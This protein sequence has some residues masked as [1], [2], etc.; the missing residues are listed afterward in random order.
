VGETTLIA[1]GIG[2]NG[3]TATEQFSIEIS[4][5]NYRFF[6][7]S[8]GN[9]YEADA[10]VGPDGTWQQVVAVDDDVG[11]NMYI[12]IN[13]ELQDSKG[14]APGGLN[15]TT[16]PVS[17][18]SKRTG[19]D[20]NYNGGFTGTID[21]VAIYG[22]A[23]SA[24]QVQAHY[25]AAYGPSLPPTISKQP[26]SLTN[27]VTLPGIFSVGV[28]GTV[29][30]SYQWKKGGVPLTDD[31]I[32]INGA[33][34]A[35]L[36]VS[37]LV[38]G[39]SGNYSV[40]ITNVNGT[41]NSATVTLTVLAAPVTPPAIPGLV[42]HLPFDNNL[43]D[44]TG[45]GNNGTG[46]H[47]GA[48]APASFVGDGVLGAA[49]HYETDTNSVSTNYVSLGVRPD[50]Q[51]GPGV[52]FSVAYWIRLPLGYNKGDLPFLCNVPNSTFSSGGFTFAP[53]YGDHGTASTGTANG[54][55]GMSVYD[56]AGSG[57]G[58][59]GDIHTIDNSQWHHL[60]HVIDRDPTTA[61]TV[62]YLD[63]K[64]ARGN[65][66]NGTTAGAAGDLT[67]TNATI[68]GQDSTGAYFENGSAEIDDLGIW[69]KALTPL[70]AASIYVAATVNGQSFAG[71]ATLPPISIQTLA[72]GKVK[73][74]WPVGT[75]TLATNV[76]GPYTDVIGA[77]SPL[78]NTVSGAKYYRTRL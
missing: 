42:L 33:A 14:A 63:G 74:T 64:L 38:L 43:T 53:T 70:E 8:G 16:S 59:Y 62:T 17:I 34:T 5:G 72:G 57:I 21:E 75:L 20:P 45:R 30:L 6:I 52:Q 3:T 11:G 69:R 26:S 56:F 32:H 65:R 55:W 31:V 7:R 35:N 1:K 28:Y 39:D 2:A 67:T 48:N 9:V 25:A 12:Y 4:G 54:G 58:I 71:T 27:Y 36:K 76:I 10:T 51:F 47:N 23:L 15:T 68:I 19:N 40:T 44:T 24:P 66:Q 41:T 22:F 60:V 18:G 50:L 37:P 29:P 73:L 78:T 13:G 49:L 46:K 77:T 61:G